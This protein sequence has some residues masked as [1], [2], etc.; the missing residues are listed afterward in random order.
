MTKSFLQLWIRFNNG[1]IFYND[2]KN[3]TYFQNARVLSRRQ[4][5]W[6][7]FLTHFDFIIYRPGMQQGKA[8]ALSRRSYMELRL[9][10]PAFEHKKNPFGS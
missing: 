4:A 2:H 3:L 6:A 10:E 5:R 1:D 7:Q 9:G 8:Y